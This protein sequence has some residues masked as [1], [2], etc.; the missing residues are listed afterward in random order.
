MLR[1]SVPT[2]SKTYITDLI[3]VPGMGKLCD[4]E[5]CL[6]GAERAQGIDENGT[7]IRQWTREKDCEGAFVSNWYEMWAD[8]Q[9]LKECT[10]YQLCHGWDAIPL[11]E[12]KAQK[13]RRL[14]MLQ[15]ANLLPERPL[16]GRV[17]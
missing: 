13:K 15:K 6:C 7:V 12:T 14:E 5:A 1:N 2:D 16:T 10:Y 8:G 17:L 3:P 4:D 9:G 11:R